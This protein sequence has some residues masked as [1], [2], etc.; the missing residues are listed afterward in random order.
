MNQAD[1]LAQVPSGWWWSGL[2]G[3]EVENTYDRIPLDRLPSIRRDLSGKWDWVPTVAAPL[4][5]SIADRDDPEAFLEDAEAVGV[6]IPNSLRGFILRPE[7]RRSIRSGTGCWW[8]L[9]EGRGVVARAAIVEA[10]R[11]KGADVEV[12]EHGPLAFVPSLGRYVVRFLTDQQDCIFWF[13]VLGDSDG[14]VI[15]SFDDL[16]GELSE[17]PEIWRV[18]STFEEFMYR[19]WIENEIFFRM[20]ERVALTAEQEAYYAEARR[21]A[22]VTT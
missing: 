9:G 15:A 2:P 10:M 7:L 13:L 16:T 1:P 18:S 12:D 3:L 8:S 14:P 4:D 19:F 21:L 6:P 20:N 22:D 17:A 5:W 11:E